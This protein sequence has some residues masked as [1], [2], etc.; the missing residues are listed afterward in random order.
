MS[1]GVYCALSCTLRNYNCILK[2]LSQSQLHCL[3]AIHVDSGL[4]WCWCYDTFRLAATRWCILVLSS[5]EASFPINAG[6]WSCCACVALSL[7]DVGARLGSARLLGRPAAPALA[8][9]VGRASLDGR[10][11][12]QQKNPKSPK[13]ALGW[14]SKQGKK[15]AAPFLRWSHPLGGTYGPDR[16]NTPNNPCRLSSLCLLKPSFVDLFWWKASFLKVFTVHSY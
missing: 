16:W 13:W 5:S 9:A 4:F 12:A 6:R 14:R 15:Q 11:A 7:Y 8:A 10:V 1:G 2:N 3:F